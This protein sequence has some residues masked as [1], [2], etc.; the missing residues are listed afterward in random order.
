MTSLKIA[1]WNTR[2]SPPVP[3]PSQ[4]NQTDK[5][6]A[7]KTILSLVDEFDVVVLGEVSSDDLRWLENYLHSDIWHMAD[8]TKGQT[9]NRF[10]IGA[11]SRIERC[12]ILSTELLTAK[13]GG[14]NFKIAAHIKF[15]HKDTLIVDL[16]AVH[17][18]SRLTRGA[19]SHDRTHF[20]SSLRN[21][22]D[23]IAREGAGFVIALGDFN[24]EPF[25]LSMTKYLRATRDV[26]FVIKN[27]SLLYNPFWKRLSCRLGYDPDGG[28]SE[29]TGTY[30]H[31]GDDL[32]NWHVFDQI[33]LPRAFLGGTAWHLEE[34]ETGVMR[35]EDLVLALESNISKLD[36]LPI[37]CTLS[38]RLTND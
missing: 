32:N 15:L 36:H 7:L 20:G 4:L 13:I 29:P 1:W 38:E 17:W 11:I 14:D 12:S 27:P 28:P 5:D 24:D 26:R 23:A 10:N 18:S 2:L 33:L 35:P 22:I 8:L 6:L 3:N 19:D 9:K 16:L 37:Y 21:S 30:F 25:D 34:N 31:K